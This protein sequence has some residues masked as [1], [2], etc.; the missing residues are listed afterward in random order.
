MDELKIL[1]GKKV[2]VVDDEPDVIETLVDLL[3]MCQVD[4]A[5]DF[6]SAKDLLDKNAYDLVILDIMGVKGYDLLEVTQQK[7][8]PA[9]MLT[10]HALS[11]EAF[12][13]SLQG[14][15][16]AYIP[17][18]KMP[19]IASYS[20]QLLTD[21]EQGIERPTGWFNSLKSFFAIL[22]GNELKEKVRAVHEKYPWL[23]LEE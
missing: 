9:L 21:L 13:K 17:K 5:A 20:A 11:L 16:K 19:E 12:D 14:G 8:L 1:E 3:D 22:F 15:A 10:A 4:T 6:E 18:E 7:G 2:L 23:D